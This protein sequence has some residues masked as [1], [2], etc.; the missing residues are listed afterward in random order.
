M[1]NKNLKIKLIKNISNI[2][3]IEKDFFNGNTYIMQIV[4]N[5]EH[6]FSE[7]CSLMDKTQK[8][9][10]KENNNLQV[11]LHNSCNFKDFEIY[12]LKLY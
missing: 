12:I 5:K 11:H 2:D 10:D 7:Y 4:S 9:F 8:I 1:E 6:T 3:K